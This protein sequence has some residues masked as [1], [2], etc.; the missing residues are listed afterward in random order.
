MYLKRLYLSLILLC[1]T[2]CCLGKPLV[3]I[4]ATGGT[5]AGTANS[6][7]SSI[8]KAG[9][10]TAE[11]ITASV[12][13]I[14]NLADIKYVQLY[15]KDSG[16]ITL[17]DW[18]MLNKKVNELLANS[19]VSAVIITHGTDTME[20]TAYLLNLTVK[21]NKPVVIVGA[22]R[23]ATALSPD[24]PLN[25]YNAAAVAVDKQSSGRGVLVVMN[26]GVYNA[27]DVIKT[28]TNSVDTFKSLNSGAIGIVNMGNVK[29]Y[30]HGERKNTNATPFNIINRQSLPNVAI[31][32]EYAG[33][34]TTM[35][36]NLLKD[37]TLKGIVF[38]G[39]GDGNI[40]NYESEFLR[41]AKK[42]GIILVRSSRVPSGVNTDNYNN[43]D[44]DYGTI[45]AD[46]LSPQKARILLMLALTVTTDP[47]KIKQF[48]ATY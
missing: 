26:D 4:V 17:N 8:Y 29:Y 39:L 40:P 1:I 16:D 3:Y 18:L 25:L 28:N 38:A 46:D 11:Q 44:A 27:R 6:Q 32:Y 7:T 47:N 23:A 5:I 36:M 22:M 35:L 12:P 41:V 42:H 13:E 48:F 31:I 37:N 14:N 43:L 30:M 24:G 34:N 45:A 15:N 2:F 19:K 21:S 9:S 10:L 20:E 33:V